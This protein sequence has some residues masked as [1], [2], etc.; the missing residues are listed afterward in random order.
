MEYV[1]VGDS[2][3]EPQHKDCLVYVCRTKERAEEVLEQ[4]LNNPDETDKLN[5][6]RYTNFRI[7]TVED[8]D[9]W[10]NEKFD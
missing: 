10:W 9:C 3:Q 7:D 5:L 1:I 2:I 8:K 6:K 4:L